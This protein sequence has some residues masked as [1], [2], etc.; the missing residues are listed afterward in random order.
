MDAHALAGLLHIHWGLGEVT[1]SPLDGGM[2]SETWLVRA[3]NSSYVAKRVAPSDVGQLDA[4]CA[5][6]EQLAS[7]GLATCRPV[8]TMDG[9]FVA[10]GESLALLEY[11]PGREL[12]GRTSEEQRWI[13]HTLARVHSAG[14]PV[15]GSPDS[16][17]FF[18]RLAPSASGTGA[19]SWLPPAIEAARV[20]AGRLTVTW[21]VLHAD[22]APEAFRYEDATGTTGLIDWTGH[23]AGPCSTTSRPR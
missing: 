11:V 15:S 4:G 8:R 19:H 21:S 23:V 20:A 17:G 7:S 10:P 12:A 5:V 16:T 22:P 18:E 2:N 14:G 9:T 13:G 1:V 3:G 6:A